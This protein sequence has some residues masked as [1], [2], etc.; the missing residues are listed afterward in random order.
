MYIH[1]YIAVGRRILVEINLA[2]HLLI[3][4]SYVDGNGDLWLEFQ[5]HI[6]HAQLYCACLGIALSIQCCP[7]LTFYHDKEKCIYKYV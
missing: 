4:S 5:V 1:T 7:N 6:V 2:V 3:Q